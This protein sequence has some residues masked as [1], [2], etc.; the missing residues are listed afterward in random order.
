MSHS[1]SMIK[2]TTTQ[3]HEGTILYTDVRKL[4]LIISQP[5]LFLTETS[6]FKIITGAMGALVLVICIVII[7]LVFVSK[8]KKRVNSSNE[9]IN[10]FKPESKDPVQSIIWKTKISKHT[11]SG[12]SL[13]IDRK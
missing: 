5:S 8:K 4:G 2:C 3:T 12:T 1:G 13:A 10:N 11:N 7:V 6:T 9:S